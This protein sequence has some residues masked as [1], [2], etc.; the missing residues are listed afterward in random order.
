M[1]RYYLIGDN[2]INFMF[3]ITLFVITIAYLIFIAIIVT[4]VI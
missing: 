2:L 4:K 1:A 3:F